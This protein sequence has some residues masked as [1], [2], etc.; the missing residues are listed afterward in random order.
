ML[1]ILGACWRFDSGSQIFSDDGYP[2]HMVRY[3]RRPEVPQ[4]E[5]I[6]STLYSSLAPIRSGGGFEKL[7]PCASVS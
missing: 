3:L 2:F 6:C 5:I 4:C 7:G 1:S